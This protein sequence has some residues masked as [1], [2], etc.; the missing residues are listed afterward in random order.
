MTPG[1][2]PRRPAGRWSEVRSGKGPFADTGRREI[3]QG[4]W[5][6]IDVLFTRLGNLCIVYQM[7]RNKNGISPPRTIGY[8]RDQYDRTGTADV[9]GGAA[10]SRLPGSVSV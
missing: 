6:R 9:G 7:K 5:I 4:A 1:G 8:A 3:G 2:Q 10:G